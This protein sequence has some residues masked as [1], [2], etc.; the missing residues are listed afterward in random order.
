MGLRLTFIIPNGTW[1]HLVLPLTRPLLLYGSKNNS[2]PSWTLIRIVC[3]FCSCCVLMFSLTLSVLVPIYDAHS[4]SFMFTKEDFVGLPSFPRF[5][6]PGDPKLAD[7]PP[8]ALVTVFFTM[9]TYLSTRAP[10]TPSSI[11]APVASSSSQN[12]TSAKGSSTRADDPFV[13]SSSSTQVLSPNLQ[14][15]LYHG[16]IPDEADD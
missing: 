12:N 5:K 15:L 10:P 14:F 8:N 4:R 2:H 13:S 9:N 7:L 6:K 16:M 3:A 1:R 11:K